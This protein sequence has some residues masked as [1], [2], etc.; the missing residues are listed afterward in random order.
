MLPAPY[1]ST[2]ASSTS[3]GCSEELLLHSARDCTSPACCG[4]CSC[5]TAGACNRSGSSTP[6]FPCCSGCSCCCCRCTWD[7]YTCRPEAK[8]LP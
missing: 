5:E 8:A 1:A 2:V 4:S 3:E 7:Q 6:S